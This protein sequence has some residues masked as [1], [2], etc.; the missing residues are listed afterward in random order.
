MAAPPSIRQISRESLGEVPAWF[1]RV[2]TP[3]NSFIQQ[4]VDTLGNGLTPAQ[5]FAQQWVEF[6]ATEGTNTYP[7]QAVS[8]GGRAVKG[9]SVESVTLLAVGGSPPP[10]PSTSVPVGIYW[11]R[12][13]V[14]QAGA[15][16]P[17]FQVTGVVGLPVGGRATL[18]LLVKA[19]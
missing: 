6:Q 1:L 19:E 11:Q 8:L 13:S 18:T 7:A 17:G 5:N 14:Q 12:V 4:V 15:L 2:L 3:L 16:V 9:I 10:A